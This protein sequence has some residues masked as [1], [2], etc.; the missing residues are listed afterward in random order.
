MSIET[1]HEHNKSAEV[2]F[3]LTDLVGFIWQKKLRIILSSVAIVCAGI[4]YISG[5]PMIYS[6]SSRIVLGDNDPSFSLPAV[7]SDFGYGGES[8]LD[9]YI[10]FIRSRQFIGGVVDEMELTKTPE[11]KF[12]GRSR[13]PE[14]MREYAIDVLLNGLTLN[15]IGDTYLL[16]ISF[17]SK[18]PNIAADVAN[19]IGPAFFV[20]H[21]KISAEKANDTSNW[22]YDQLGALENKL[23]MAEDALQTYIEENQLIGAN[24]QIEFAR[25]EILILLEEKLALEKTLAAVKSSLLQ[26]DSAADD[27]KTLKQVDYIIKHPMMINIRNNLLA[28]QQ[29]FSQISKRYKSKHHRYIAAYAAI[30]KLESEERQLVEQLIA[31]LRQNLSTY[32][33]RLESLNGQMSKAEQKH[34]ELSRY[35]LQLT[36]LRREIEST[37]TLY[38]EFV[39]R[40]QETQMLKD[41]GKTNQFSVVDY[42]SVP[43][44]P[45]KPRKLML[46]VVVCL[47]AVVFSSGGWLLLHLIR[48]KQTRFRQLLRKLNVPLL[49]EIPKIKGSSSTKNIAKTLS[50]GERDY[51]FAESIRSLRTAVLMRSDE[52]RGRTIA[53]TGV[54]EGDGKTTVSVSLAQ[55]FAK[56][57]KVILVDSD[58]RMPSVD[59][60]F[61]LSKEQPG[62]SNFIARRAKF[63]DCLYRQPETRLNVLASGPTPNDPMIHLS[64]PRFAQLIKKLSE[65]YERVVLEAPSVNSVS[66]ILVISK[67][68]DSVILVCDIEK[69]ESD[70]LIETVQSLRENGVPLLGVVLNKVKRV[71]PK[72]RKGMMRQA[73][74]INKS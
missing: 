58:L 25:A 33:L 18:Y 41:L 55:A 14:E 59:Q 27:I 21:A 66:D 44:Y 67:H 36:K 39:S 48:D 34:S 16:R 5:L 52:F 22:L 12:T 28:S 46:L 8:I 45:S 13:S 62:L 1:I 69:L 2:S 30:K 37:Q 53:L 29:A 31:G 15:K 65:I 54:H 57:E 73:L 47:F 56:L 63:S 3:D 70:S 11:F 32:E 4:Y 71:S 35:E 60:V 17:E 50:Q 20:Y 19:F 68:V 38:E 51:V 26:V 49:A 23:V 9:T 61:G 64:R 24:S 7:V 42:A 72:R 6:A 43:I 40:L 74:V 10:E